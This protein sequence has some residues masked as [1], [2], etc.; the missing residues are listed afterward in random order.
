MNLHQQHATHFSSRLRVQSSDRITPNPKL[1]LQ[2]AKDTIVWLYEGSTF[3]KGSKMRC[4]GETGSDTSDPRLAYSELMKLRFRQVKQ[5]LFIIQKTSQPP[6]VKYLISRSSQLTMLFTC[7]SARWRA[8]TLRDSSAN[9]HFV[10]CVKS[11][12]IYCRPNCSARLARR[13]NVVFHDSPCQAEAA[14]FR[15]CK[16]CQPNSDQEISPAAIAVEKACAILATEAEREAKQEHMQKE[17]E[18]LKLKDL[19]GMVGLTSSHFHKIFRQR[20]GMTP[21]TYFDSLKS[22]EI[23]GKMGVQF[24]E[25][26][27]ETNAE[28]TNQAK[29]SEIEGMLAPPSENFFAWNFDLAEPQRM[30]GDINSH[31]PP[32]NIPIVTD[33]LDVPIDQAWFSQMLPGFDQRLIDNPVDG[34][35]IKNGYATEGWQQMSGLS[36]NTLFPDVLRGST[37]DLS[38]TLYGPQ[39]LFIDDGILRNG[40]DVP[41]IIQDGNVFY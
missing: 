5:R 11:T 6:T 30:D 27:V 10:Y 26:I 38:T 13:A 29:A 32:S 15:P 1:L 31:S 40:M 33:I 7:D 28:E 2:I 9:G 24:E 20:T 21:K 35:I 8:L 36:S 19:A 41:E 12:G 22:A 23:D 25:L 16:R 39:G 18:P 34:S 37:D 3:A 14:G 17:K 4:D